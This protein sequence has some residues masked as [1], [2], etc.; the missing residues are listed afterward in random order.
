MKILLISLLAAYASFA[1]AGN[2]IVVS[3]SQ[4]SAWL[5]DGNDKVL[6]ESP[7]ATGLHHNTPT[8]HFTIGE[9]DILHHSSINYSWKMPYY[10]HLAGEPFGLHQYYMPYISPDG[11]HGRIASHGCIRMPMDKAI[12]FYNRVEVGTPVD[13]VK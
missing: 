1:Q 11:L 10:M 3:L 4:Q 8:G 7:V 5:L 6:M 12:F 2:H 13:I 9:K